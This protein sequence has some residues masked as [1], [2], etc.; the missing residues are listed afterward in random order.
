MKKSK[1]LL[2]PNN[3]LREIKSLKKDEGNS[4][5]ILKELEIPERTQIPPSSELIAELNEIASK[6][7]FSYL[8]KTKEN[9]TR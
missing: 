7:P 3:K 4:N 5:D 9:D 8:H 6:P 2:D 1:P